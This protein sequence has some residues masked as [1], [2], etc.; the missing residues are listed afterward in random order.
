MSAKGFQE[1]KRRVWDYWRELDAAEP[2]QR[3]DTIRRH[4][5]KDIQWHGPAPIDS[6]KGVDAVIENMWTPL[7]RSFS[8]LRRRCDIF[9]GGE[10]HGKKWVS[11]TGYFTGT[12]VQN[13]VGIPATQ[14]EIFVQYGEFCNLED[15]LIKTSYV[16]Y[17]VI[18]VAR[19]AGFSLLPGY[20]GAAVI[21]PPP[22][23]NGQL[24][25]PQDEEESRIS[26]DLLVRM[27]KGL[28]SYNGRDVKTVVST[29]T[30]IFDYQWYGPSPLGYCRN[31]K[32]FEDYHQVPWLL[33]FP[34]R[35]VGD[36]KALFGEGKFVC[37]SGWPM[38][39][40]T[41]TGDYIGIPAT[42]KRLD[43]RCMDWFSR[44]GSLLTGNRVWFDLV[45]LAR[46]MGVDVLERA[47]S[48]S[49]ETVRS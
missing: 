16:G 14:K 8:N 30:K 17:D 19:Q 3:A 25:E 39:T 11:S 35:V 18:D 9:M 43:L 26:R 34:D 41:Q 33:A 32:E 37:C 10:Y 5:H 13:W 44:E 1:D 29:S 22:K 6:L 20:G 2:R 15:G 40:M 23:Q 31:L 36:H 21:A 38:L 46:Q 42:G 4:T 48:R 27:E 24:L 12:F 7:F 28:N 49:K 45:D 47:L